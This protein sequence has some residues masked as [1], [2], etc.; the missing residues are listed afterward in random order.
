MKWRRIQ[1]HPDEPKV[2][3][4][5]HPDG[6]PM[7][8]Y[9]DRGTLE[10]TRYEGKLGTFPKGYKIPQEYIVSPTTRKRKGPICGAKKDDLS[11]SGGGVCCQPAG[12]GT[13]HKGSGPCKLHGGGLPSVNRNHIKKLETKRMAVYGDKI[14]VDPHQAVLDTVH[15]TAGHVAWLF[16]KIQALHEVE[17]DMT[18]HQYTS[19][20]IRASVW[21]EMY[22]R[23]RMML[24]RAS[25]AAV[26]MGVSE[27]QVQLA[28]EQGRMI[29]MV[30]QQF[31]DSAEI[32]L[33]PQ[34][35]ALAPKVIRQLLTSMPTQA[36]P[37]TVVRRADPAPLT[38]PEGSTLPSAEADDDWEEF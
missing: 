33:T 27:R 5:C 21:V 16:D 28:E 10:R 35:R 13:E 36:A 14:E 7:L 11:M 4:P 8:R 25:K 29:A 26:D 12:W 15:R 38:P 32:K 20:G 34:Q 31:I 37:G 22:E 6:S 18:L 17:G 23:E 19:M 1:G 2:R 3:V 9:T 24:L 30:L